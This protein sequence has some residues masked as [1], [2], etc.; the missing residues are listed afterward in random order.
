MIHKNLRQ[1]FEM[2][3]D[4]VSHQGKLI[5]ELGNMQSKHRRD[6]LAPRD[7]REENQSSLGTLHILGQKCSVSLNEQESGAH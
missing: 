4:E 2:V 5:K 1:A 3:T 7:R 6:S